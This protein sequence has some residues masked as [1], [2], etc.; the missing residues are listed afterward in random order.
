MIVP[1]GEDRPDPLEAEGP[2]D[3]PAG[4]PPSQGPPSPGLPEGAGALLENVAHFARLLRRAGMPLGPGA[5]LDAVRA[6]EAVGV[7][8]RADVYWALHAVLVSAPDQRA[9]FRTAFDTFWRDPFGAEQALSALAPRTEVAERARKDRPAARRVAGAAAGPSAPRPPSES[10]TAD[11]L[12]VVMSWTDREVLRTRDFEQMTAE[13]MEE[14]R[15]LLR[16]MSLKLPRRPTRRWRP[17]PTG[18]SADLRATL[19][20][21][22]RSGHGIIPLQRRSR[23]RR[24]PDLVVLCD[25]SGSME[26]YA[27]MLLHFLQGLTG[28]RDRVRVLLFGTRLT[29]VTRHLRHRDV[30]EALA[31]VGRAVSDWSGGTRIGASLEAFN[32]LWARRLLGHGAVV[33][34][35]TDG[36]DRDGARGIEKEA[37]RLQRSCRRLIWLNPLLRW[38]GFAPEAAGVKA[39]LR[40]VDDVRPVH[41][42][43]S[44]ESLVAA[45][46][47]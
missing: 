22:L 33:L 16:R 26:R 11:E 36:L 46:E 47:G 14:A 6:V 43:E 8:R 15:V 32:R 10:P 17:D 18:S 42:L 23:R 13:E 39:L 7:R 9:L 27:R 12:D 44:L 3:E 34:L 40:H 19:R 24:P 28:A 5:T 29:D 37:A 38:E 20:A 25:I 21:S 35:I 2:A 45:L 31:R 41:N 30:D 4:E 1:P